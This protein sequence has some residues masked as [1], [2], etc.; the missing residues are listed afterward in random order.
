[1][2][3]LGGHRGQVVDSFVRA[4]GVEEVDPVEGLQLDVLDTAPGSFSPDQFGLVQP[5]L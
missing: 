1:V 4:L 5:D 3:F 2:K